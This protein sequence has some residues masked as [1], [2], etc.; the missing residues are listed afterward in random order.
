MGCRPVFDVETAT[1]AL[2]TGLS[3]G[4]QAS[5]TVNRVRLLGPLQGALETGRC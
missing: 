2:L 1:D 3:S 4:T 5:L